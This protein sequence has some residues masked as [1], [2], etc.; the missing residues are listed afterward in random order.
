MG[1]DREVAAAAEDRHISGMTTSVIVR[2]VRGLAGE[3]GVQRLLER[4]GEN[5]R[6]AEIEN[7]ASWSS[8]WQATALLEAAV[9]VTGRTD[10]ARRVGEEMLA[11]HRETPVFDLLRSLG[12]PE[13]LLMSIAESGT[14]FSTI[15]IIEPRE[16]APGRA[17][18]AG[19][20]PQGIPRHRLLCDFTSGI[21]SV[22]PSV[23][24]MDAA[25]VSESE[26]QARGGE[27]CVYHL[28]WDLASSPDSD[29][30]RRIGYLEDELH[31]LRRR[32]AS[33]QRTAADVI[34]TSDVETA[35]QAVADR[36]AAALGATGYL[37]AVRLHPTAKPLLFGEGRPADAARFA[38]DDFHERYD[39]GGGARIV[40]E[41]R[42]GSRFYGRM[43][44]FYPPGT[45]FFSEERELLLAYA[46]HA[47]AVLDTAAALDEARRQNGTARAVLRLS[48]TLSD[49]WDQDEV[50]Q[51]LVDAVPEL[52]DCDRSSV[53]LW[54]DERERLYL[55]A[56]FGPPSPLREHLETSGIAEADTPKLAE[57][58][59]SYMPIFL[60]SDET[61]PYLRELLVNGGSVVVAVVPIVSHGIFHGVVTAEVDTQPERLRPDDDLMERMAGI[62]YHGAAALESAKLMHG[63]RRQAM[64]DA[65]TGLPNRV[66]LLDRLQQALAA[67][68]RSRGLVALMFLDLDR[69]KEVNDVFGHAA[70]DDLL[71][72][73]AGR[74]A[75][76]VR[77]YD[78]VARLG[79][80]EFAV[81][82]P[83]VRDEREAVHCA[84]RL[85]TVM[86]APFSLDDTEFYVSPSIGI[87]LAGGGATDA[88]TLL[89]Q[90][91]SAMY[92]AK[93]HG[94]GVFELAG[95]TDQAAAS[96]RRLMLESALRN[97]L[98]Q[99]QLRVVYQPVVDSVEQSVVGVEALVRWHHP[100]LRLL[101]PGEFLDVA[102]EVGVIVDIDLWMLQESCAQLRRWLAQGRPP[103][104]M[105]VNLSARTVR[106][107]RLPR[108][109]EE[110]L[111][112]GALAGLL[113]L[114]IS[115]RVLD[116]ELTEVAQRLSALAGAG[117]TIAIDDFG[118]G[119]SSFARL[120]HEFVETLK[121]DSGFLREVRSA[122]S[123]APV[124]EALLRMGDDMGLRVV[125][126]GVERKAQSV[127]LRRHGCRY[128][129][130]YLH[131]R[132]VSPEQVEPLLPLPVA[133][134]LQ[135]RPVAAPA[136]G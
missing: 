52:V 91:D 67:T 38:D 109:V 8:Y 127:W 10:A 92:A 74:L 29:P 68:T 103:L 81:L 39:D 132:P 48:A 95:G 41:V 99:D 69:F 72:Q 62:A 114:E 6:L 121:I 5:R 51:R 2:W 76:G 15:L 17:V 25:M 110:Q 135:R 55:T 56:T 12:S 7:P 105:A 26:C 111:A 16:V 4:A 11:Q 59:A 96:R 112:D 37:L 133:T 118:T 85:L 23:F 90:A 80:D 14:K 123:T 27:A 88:L 104:R 107:S 79:G 131:G 78:T 86:E 106:S 54:D 115:E 119:N 102:E 82:L 60:T 24:G 71:A 47:A 21:L 45:K 77:Q 83:Q 32:L 75:D 122:D 70:G 116:A 65:L 44:A 40:V 18:V 35:L 36:A 130:G 49:V 19:S 43:V 28:Q 97:A 20:T 101:N 58:R 50:A 3:E 33:L 113:E 98:G 117:A 9:S 61:D 120:H 94:G 126:E 136:E 73:V 87:A 89:R 22:V 108:A 134:P 30:V 31:A 128:A 34:A 46:A 124:L 129:Q 64:R 1:D 13:A 93:S 53:L 57:M 66:L 63:L 42:S 84:R 125:A 100:D